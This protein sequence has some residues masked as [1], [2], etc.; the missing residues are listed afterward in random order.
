[1]T[2]APVGPLRHRLGDQQREERADETDDRGE[3]QQA[4]VTLMPSALSHVLRPSTLMITD[5]STTTARLVGQEQHD[6]F[7]G[8]VFLQCAQ[9]YLSMG[10]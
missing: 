5:S 2:C 8:L 4:K 3:D 6:S 9:V 7:H 1:M 10:C